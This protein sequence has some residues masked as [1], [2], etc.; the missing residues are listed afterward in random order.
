VSFTRH[1]GHLRCIVTD[2]YLISK[3][4][5]S[6]QACLLGTGFLN[7]RH[8]SLKPWITAEETNFTAWEFFTVNINACVVAKGCNQCLME[9]GAA[10]DLTLLHYI[11]SS[12]ASKL[13][14]IIFLV[15]GQLL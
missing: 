15:V 13:L 9:V 4:F 1:A 3:Y 8:V 2:W 14:V 11:K 6:K 5:A 12:V 7:T 10:L